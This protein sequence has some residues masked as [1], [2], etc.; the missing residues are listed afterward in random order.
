[1][2]PELDALA[3]Y[4]DSIEALVSPYVDNHERV[5]SG[6]KQFN[7]LGCQSCH[8]PPLFT[9]RHL[10]DVGTGDLR[11]EKNA[12]GRGPS[13][14]TPSLRALWLTAPYFHDGSALTLEDVLD[15]GTAHNIS[16]VL[17]SKEVEDLV[18]YLQSLP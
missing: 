2:S 12:H 7:A 14:D 10:H 17:T 13:V 16:A 3:A 4:M 6:E 5:M 9:D 15:S 1:M 11:K 18:A 8:T